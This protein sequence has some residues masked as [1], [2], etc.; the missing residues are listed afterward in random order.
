MYVYSQGITTYS[1]CLWS[2]LL[3]SCAQAGIILSENWTEDVTEVQCISDS[4]ILLKLIIGKAIFTFPSVYTPQV[5]R[6]EPVKERFYNQLQ[7]AVVKVPASEILIPYD[8]CNGHVGAPASV[9]TW[10]C[11]WGRS[12]DSK[13]A[14]DVF[15]CGVIP[16]DWEVSFILNLFRTIVTMA[17]T[18]GSSSQIKSWS[19]Q[20]ATSMVNTEGMQFGFVPGKVTTDAIFAIRQLQ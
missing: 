13:T 3:L 7:Y 10:C 1:N 2:S 17:T 11:W 12:W 14:E 20:T 16:S 18:V 9:W 19:C 8:D 4:I 5:G 15:S 6:S